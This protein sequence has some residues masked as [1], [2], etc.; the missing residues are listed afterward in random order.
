MEYYIN[1]TNKCNLRCSFCCS[2]KIVFKDEKKEL[3]NDEIKNILC[4]IRKDIIKHSRE[5]NR[6]VFYGGEP[7]VVPHIIERIIRDTSNLNVEYMLYTNGVLLNKIPLSILERL[8]IILVSF[9]G[10]K[11][12]QEKYRGKGTYQKVIKNLKILTPNIKNKIIGRITVEEETDIFLSATNLLKYVPIVHWQ[13]VNKPR[14]KNSEKFIS[15]YN[16][17]VLKLWNYWLEKFENGN[18]LRIIPFQSIV[19]LTLNKDIK[20]KSFRCGCGYF[21][22]MIDMNGDIYECPESI[23]Y[24]NKIIG[25]IKGKSNLC[26][27]AHINIWPECKKCPVSEIC[28]GRCKK[29]LTIYS[30]SHLKEY[31]KM[32]KYLI[33]N[34]KKDTK[35]IKNAINK[36][37]FTIKDI[38][39]GPFC[40]EE[41]P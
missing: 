23:G 12:T 27:E 1:L 39:N 33:E 31:C 14:F 20:R 18:I 29:N 36:Y 17:Q 3:N 24:H 4:Y 16:Q 13:I 26:Y 37:Q 41:I 40:T 22:Q 9:D 35:R 21:I 32:T 30:K 8:N 15:N 5:V 2:C 7:F 25:N 28:L 38:Y 10:D 19:M 6:V 11:K 34:I